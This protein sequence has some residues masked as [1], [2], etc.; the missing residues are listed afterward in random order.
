MVNFFLRIALA[1]WGLMHENLL[2]HLVL[3]VMDGDGFF[4][5][6]SWTNFYLLRTFLLQ[7]LYL[8]Q[9]SQNWRELGPCSRLDIGIRECCGWFDLSKPLKLSLYE[10]LLLSHDSCVHRVVL[11]ITFKNISFAF[12][13]WS[14]IWYK[15]ARFEDVFELNMPFPQSLIVSS[16]WLKVRDMQL[17]RSLE[18]T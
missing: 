6:T 8:S 17:I 11:L 4:L 18:H 5:W 9:L 2:L 15:R 16:I 3:Y 1:I 7:L 12:I 14:A 10:A 13:I